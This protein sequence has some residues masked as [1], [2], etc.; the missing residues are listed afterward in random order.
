MNLGVACE[1]LM[2]QFQKG[3]PYAWRAK[4]YLIFIFQVVPV[5][6]FFPKPNY[7][8]YKGVAYKP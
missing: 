1:C 2:K 8:A 5:D 7:V 3:V 4:L 6:N